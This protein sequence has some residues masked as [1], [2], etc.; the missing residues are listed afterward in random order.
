MSEA[1]RVM[2][3]DLGLERAKV[4]ELE[5]RLNELYPKTDSLLQKL[6]NEE[7]KKGVLSDGGANGH[8]LLENQ[9]QQELIISFQSTLLS[10]E[11]TIQELKTTLGKTVQG[12][13]SRERSQDELDQLNVEEAQDQD[14]DGSSE[15]SCVEII[16]DKL[17]GGRF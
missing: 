8:L 11:R 13:Q 17:S 2:A 5:S 10:R 4:Q 3:R 1:C 9:H 14:D 6:A 12:L 16:T 7:Q 15:E